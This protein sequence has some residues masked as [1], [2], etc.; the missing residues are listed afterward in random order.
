MN[1]PFL[2]PR[3]CPAGVDAMS[4][5]KAL[6]AR[7]EELLA[8]ADVLIDALDAMD[9][10]PDRE[11]FLGAAESGPGFSFRGE[12]G[13]QTLWGRSAMDDREEENEHGG[14]ALDDHQLSRT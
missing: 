5:R 3:G 10:D 4:W 11:P 8:S 6:S 2:R 13:D 14:D 12:L 1:A 9:G 7:I